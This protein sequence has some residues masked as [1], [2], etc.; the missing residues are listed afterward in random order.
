MAWCRGVL[1]ILIRVRRHHVWEPLLPLRSDVQGRPPVSHGRHP[2]V[3]GAPPVTV[4]RIHLVQ[5]ISIQYIL[6]TFIIGIWQMHLHVHI[7]DEPYVNSG[8]LT[9]HHSVI[10]KRLFNS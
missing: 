2:R 4:V 5:V 10:S 8:S 3:E 1:G 9:W 6:F 7:I